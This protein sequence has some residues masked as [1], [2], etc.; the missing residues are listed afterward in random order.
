MLLGLFGSIWLI[1]LDPGGPVLQV[2]GQHRFCP[3]HHEEW[4]EACRTIRHRPQTP[5]YWGGGGSTAHFP[6]QVLSWA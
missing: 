3:I 2:G 1:V 4:G 5:E 6:S